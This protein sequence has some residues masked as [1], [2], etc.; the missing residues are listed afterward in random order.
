[1]LRAVITVSLVESVAAQASALLA[2]NSQGL[3]AI[4]HK[5]SAFEQHAADGSKI[6]QLDWE[7]VTDQTG[8]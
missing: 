7:H 8:E 5:P 2:V 3:G 1:M 4:T 6:N